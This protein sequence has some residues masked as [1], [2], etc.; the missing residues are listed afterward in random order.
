MQK[1]LVAALFFAALHAHSADDEID[2]AAIT[3]AYTRAPYRNKTFEPV[4][5]PSL[6]KAKESLADTDM[7][8]ARSAESVFLSSPQNLGMM[9]IDKNQIIYER[10]A[11]GLDEKTKYFSYSMGKSLTAYAV[12]QAYCGGS[13]ASL[14]DKAV[15]YAKNLEGTVFGDASVKQL[16]T[17]SS[18]APAPFEAGGSAKGEWRSVTRQ[19]STIEQVLR[20]YG[21]TPVEER[22]YEYNNSDTNALMYVLNGAG[23][24]HKIFDEKI[25]Q[26][27]RPKS[28]GAWL[29]DKNGDAYAAAGFSATLS[30]WGRLST[31]VLNMRSGKEGACIEKFMKDATSIQKK[32]SKGYFGDD[33]GYQTWIY[34]RQ[35]SS[36]FTWRGAYGQMVAFD[37]VKERVLII[38]RHRSFGA[39]GQ[40]IGGLMARWERMP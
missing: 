5:E 32:V 14:D 1:L 7:E 15:A 36:R 3:G 6:L 11:Q 22:P 31:L 23:G 4:G 19:M 8:I 25:W 17:M 18:G 2:K 28:Q 9:L 13:I 37:P 38:F 29:I 34:S 10:Y 21:K 20:S 40:A 27:A 35:P 39:A 16:L 24:F 30:D 12:G 26:P 33:Y